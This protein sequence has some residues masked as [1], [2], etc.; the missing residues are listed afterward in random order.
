MTGGKDG[1]TGGT[2]RTL[3]TIATLL[4]LVVGIV[5]FAQSVS[6]RAIAAGEKVETACQTIKEQDTRVRILETGM[7]RIDERL[8]NIERML[9]QQRKA[10]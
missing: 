7:G 4:A 1:I 3:G 5:A 8:A 2:I 6:N 9:Q 10:P